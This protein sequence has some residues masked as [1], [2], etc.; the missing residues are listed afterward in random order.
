MPTPLASASASCTGALALSP[1]TSRPLSLNPLDTVRRLLKG[2]APAAGSPLVS[3]AIPD[4]DALLGGGFP[5]GAL[6]EI[7]SAAPGRGELQIILAPAAA[8][9]PTLWVLP[10]TDIFELSA[11]AMEAAGIDLSAQLF[12]VPRSPAEAFGTAVR[13]AA[14]HAV[15]AVA[16]W[17]PPLASLDDRRA[18]RKL[19]LAASS[20]GCTVFALRPA[21]MSCCASE[22][23]L[24]LQISPAPGASLRSLVRATHPQRLLH[25]SSEALV[26]LYPLRPAAR[27][28]ERQAA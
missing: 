17:L 5:R 1:S 14:E 26:A 3:S 19:A 12:C 10:S 21:V 18:M 7:L 6:T 4:L 22:A 24:R 28:A 15:S 2:A 20:S 23:A 8:L 9:G 27:E 11:P 13:A 25:R 16:A